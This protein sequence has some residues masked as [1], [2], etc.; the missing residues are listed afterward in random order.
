MTNKIYVGNLSYDSG[1]EDLESLFSKYGTIEQT[2]LIMDRETGRSRCFGFITFAEESSAKEAV[3][4]EN[5]NEFQGRNIKVSEAIESD[6]RGGGGG[7]GGRGGR[8]GGGGGG[9]RGGFGGGGNRGGGGGGNRG[10]N[11]W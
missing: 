1:E 9:G 7:R 5:G 11:S 10:G 2:K 4:G 8:N 3:E 6:R